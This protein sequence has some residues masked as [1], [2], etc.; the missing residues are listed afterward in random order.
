[1]KKDLKIYDSPEQLALKLSE[2]FLAAVNNKSGK[3]FVSVSGGSTPLIFFKQLAKS[4]F[5]E[6][7]EWTK[8]HFYWCDE[9]CVPPS[10]TESNFGEVK[11][12]LFD[13]ISIPEENIHRIRGEADPSTEAVRYAND[14]EHS[15]QFDSDDLPVF[16]WIF[17]GIGDDGHT[18]SLF[19]GK[20]F[21]FLYSNITVVSQ[22]PLS[23]QKRISLTKEVLCH[24]ER[25]S[26]VVTG[27][28]KAKILSEIINNIPASKNY[29]ASEIKPLNGNLEWLVDKEAAFYL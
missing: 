15:L 1:M 28:G 2:E 6:K 21:L 26:F 18:A 5:K 12:S 20:K 25:T 17:L 8:V 9:R 24:A 16:D 19:P 7:V 14:I 4:P 10:D 29:P 11:R 27:K 22:H 13:N 23:G 3:F